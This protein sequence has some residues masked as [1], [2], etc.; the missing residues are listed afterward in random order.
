M[1]ITL[2]FIDVLIHKG[3]LLS[4]LGC[5]LDTFKN[6]LKYKYSLELIEEEYM[7][8]YS[9]MSW[10]DLNFLVDELCSL[11]LVGFE[12]FEDERY[13]QDFIIVEQFS[14]RYENAKLNCKWL[15][16]NPD[17]SVDFLQ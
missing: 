13:W 7:L 10:Q 12:E 14:L 11:G 1:S 17:Y 15:K 3:K 8:S 5:G 9:S 2:S 4:L 6:D 16:L